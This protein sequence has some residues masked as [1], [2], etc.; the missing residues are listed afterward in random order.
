MEAV[1]GFAATA[2]IQHIAPTPLFM[3]VAQDDT[4]CP[5]DLALEAY[6]RALEP[7]QLQIIPGGH[8]DGY[9]GKGFEK[10]LQRQVEFLRETLCAAL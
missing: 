2:Y 9:R 4:L 8:F 5:V 10:L 3:T 1:R 6:S 7:K